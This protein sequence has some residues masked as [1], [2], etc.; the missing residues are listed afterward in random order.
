MRMN[1]IWALSTIGMD[2]W[3]LKAANGRCYPRIIYIYCAELHSSFRHSESENMCQ[4]YRWMD[5]YLVENDSMC[6]RHSSCVIYQERQLFFNEPILDIRAAMC[7]ISDDIIHWWTSHWHPS[8]YV[9]SG[10]IF[11]IHLW[12][13]NCHSPDMCHQAKTSF[14]L[15]WIN[16]ALIQWR[17]CFQ[18]FFDVYWVRKVNVFMDSK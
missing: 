16:L 17:L 14:T 18:G 4:Y 6:Y 15:T 5:L 10:M 8:Y 2:L 3:S 12:T 1:S 11:F 9:T 13:S 7:D